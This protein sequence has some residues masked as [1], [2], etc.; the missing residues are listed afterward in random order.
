MINHPTT[1]TL[2]SPTRLQPPALVIEA[3]LVSIS[4]AAQTEVDQVAGLLKKLFSSFNGNLALRLWN[5]ETFRCGKHHASELE[6][7]FTLVCRHPGVVRSMIL[8]RDPLRLAE[9]YFR[10]DIDFEGD[11]FAVLGLRHDLQAI[12]LSFFDRM[13]AML[14]ALRLRST[15]K[16]IERVTNE[17]VPAHGGSVTTHSKSENRAA[18]SP[19]AIW[20]PRACNTIKICRRTGCASAEKHPSIAASRALAVCVMRAKKVP[21]TARSEAPT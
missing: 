20:S 2:D 12:R 10:N 21:A 17:H 18:I 5:G 4:D 13:N 19:A 8:G 1:V 15:T 14:S 16:P 9:A 6:P 11:F 7:P 3:A